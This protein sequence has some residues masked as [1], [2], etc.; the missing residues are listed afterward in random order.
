M[1]IQQIRHFTNVRTEIQVWRDTGRGPDISEL[2]LQ[3]AG[4]NVGIGL[5]DPLYDLDIAGDITCTNQQELF[6]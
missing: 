2:V 1:I 5:S 3:S 4:G 6:M